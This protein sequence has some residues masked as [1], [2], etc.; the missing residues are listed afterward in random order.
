MA[1]C[2]QCQRQKGKRSC[3][4]LGGGICS[5]CCGRH[6]LKD[7]DCPS[8]CA[9]LGGLAVVRDPGSLSFSK[10]DHRAAADR[11]EAHAR[12]L[13]RF[14]DEALD[15]LY[16]DEEEPEWL[17]SLATGYLHHGYRD[18]GGLRLV[19]H[20]VSSQAAGLPPGEVAALVALQRAWASLFEVAAVQA[21]SG[22]ELRDLLS[23]ESLRVREVT[24]TA[25][26][27]RLDVVMGWILTRETHFELSG[28]LCA[29]PRMH[30]EPVRS[31][32]DRE[33]RRLRRKRPGAAARDLAGEALW[34]PARALLEACADLS[35][36]ELRT[37]DAEE[38]VFCEARYCVHDQAAVRAR[39]GGV[40]GLDDDGSGGYT[41]L[42][43]GERRTVLGS[44]SIAADGGELV[45]ETMSRERLARGRR[46]LEQALGSLIEHRTDSARS[47]EEALRDRREQA[48]EEDEHRE[49]VP[50]DQEREILGEVLRQ[51][52]RGWLDQAIPALGGKSPRRAARSKAGR[53]AVAAMLDEAENHTLAMP[54]GDAVDFDGMRRELGLAER[55]DRWAKGMVY[56]AASPPDARTW[57]LIDDTEKQMAIERHH[58]DLDDHPA[59]PNARLH[60]LL[61]V[62][63]ENQLASGEPAAVVEA[64]ERLVD[65]GLTRHEAIHAIGSVVMEEIWAMGREQ[66]RFDPE[67]TGRSLRRLRASDWIESAGE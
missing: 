33:L 54:G 55:G 22:L 6:R 45:L 19:D 1:V 51:H 12:R 52:Y 2:L 66:R 24:A 27:R 15:R 43:S 16:G 14:T 58:R 10:E 28:A 44:L 46:L 38:L 29:V 13:P 47:V 39:L 42:S 8:D 34:A 23:G 40:D 64:L 48:G 57:V 30:L 56:D 59:M 53:A 4:A 31:A 36:P 61:H 3:P 17:E 35:M 25:Q 9:W 63:V 20:L 37:T 50:P 41:W 18:A 49:V 67:A 7:I 21:G 32:L 65:G 11:L 62:V 5:S 60:A 26:L